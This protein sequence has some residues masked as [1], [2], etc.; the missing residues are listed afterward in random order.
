MSVEEAARNLGSLSN[1][2]VDGIQGV[3]THPVLDNFKGLAQ[4]LHFVTLLFQELEDVFQSFIS[5]KSPALFIPL[6]NGFGI[7]K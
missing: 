7:H 5:W 4:P 6:F 2:R 1:A 3:L